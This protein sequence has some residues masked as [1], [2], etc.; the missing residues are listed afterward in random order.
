MS[1]HFKQMGNYLPSTMS[2][3]FNLKS[4]IVLLL[5]FSEGEIA[6][7]SPYLPIPKHFEEVSLEYGIPTKIFWSIALVESG[8]L[9]QNE[10]QPWPYTLRVGESIYRFENSLDAGQKLQTVLQDGVSHIDIDIS[11][12]QLNYYWNKEYIE[13]IGYQRIFEDKYSLPRAAKILKDCLQTGTLSYCVGRYNAK[14][15]SKQL[16]YRRKVA[17]TIRQISTIP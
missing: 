9:R 3:Q 2:S 5:L 15:K 17:E 8:W 16:I 10:I 6:H 14:T 1:I 12:V 11:S 7:T 13:E 4:F